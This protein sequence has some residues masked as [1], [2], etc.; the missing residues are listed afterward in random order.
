MR[1]IILAAGSGLRLQL[2]PKEQL[3]KC[4]LRFGGQTLLER[5]LHLLR[6]AGIGN[7]VLVVGFRHALIEQALAALN[8]A[9]RP[10]VLFMTDLTL[11]VC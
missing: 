3:P 1:A 10:E 7:I 8:I 6:R 9:P 5:H 4:L 11:A 2:P